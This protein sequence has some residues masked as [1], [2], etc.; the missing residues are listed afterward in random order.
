[1][2]NIHLSYKAPSSCRVLFSSGG[3]PS[4]FSRLINFR[5]LVVP[6]GGC[7]KGV[8]IQGRHLPSALMFT[9]NSPVMLENKGG[10]MGASFST[11]IQRNSTY[12]K[13]VR[14]SIY[15]TRRPKHHNLSNRHYKLHP[16]GPPYRP[17]YRPVYCLHLPLG[18]I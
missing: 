3:G 10:V 1:M 13:T 15:E 14:R 11:P 2:L 8:I 16:Q 6:G 4:Q 5:S 9:C 7:Q 18:T 12:A 17:C